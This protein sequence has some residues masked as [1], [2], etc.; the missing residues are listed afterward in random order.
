MDVNGQGHAPITLLANFKY[1]GGR[2]PPT[3]DDDDQIHR[4]MYATGFPIRVLIEDPT[5]TRNKC[6]RESK[7]GSRTVKRKMNEMY[8][9]LLCYTQRA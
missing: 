5:S 2:F 7:F 4:F 1:L 9:S 8:I 6:H 3:T